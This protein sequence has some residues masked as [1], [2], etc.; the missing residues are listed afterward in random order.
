MHACGACAG[1]IS[2]RDALSRQVELPAAPQRIVS[3]VP[4]LTELLYELGCGARVVGVSDYCVHPQAALAQVARVGG[5]KD[6]DL[7]RLLA[8]QPELVIVAK[9]ENLRR[10][11]ERLVAA[12]V[13]VYVTDVRTL[14]QAL[15]LPSE[16]G[17]LCGAAPEAVTA[18]AQRMRAGVEAAAEKAAAQ[19]RPVRALIAV[20]Q[21]PWIVAG[22]DTYMHAVLSALRIENAAAGLDRRQRY[23]KLTADEIRALAVD[24]DVVLL[25]SEPYP[26]TAELLPAI[27]RE[28]A[29]PARLCDGTV[30]CWYGPRTARIGELLAALD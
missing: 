11:V 20:W 2:V 18:L 15:A 3:L 19:K 28:L 1:P 9:E 7:L 30:A 4:S 22:P 14:P 6:P 21:E 26:F 25:P 12:G 16:L 29:V 13:P 5:Q 17:P 24:L 10:D 23:P 8:L 27:T